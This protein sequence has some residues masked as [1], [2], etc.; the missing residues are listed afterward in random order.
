MKKYFLF[1]ISFLPLV[2]FSL[3]F[4]DST[5]AIEV[6][7]NIDSHCDSHKGE[8]V[9]PNGK[10]A[11]NFTDHIYSSWLPCSGPEFPDRIG[12]SIQKF[13][14]Y[15]YGRA[16]YDDIYSVS[17]YKNQEKVESGGPLDKLT[18]TAGTYHVWVGGGKST[19]VTIKYDL[20]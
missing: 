2:F 13:K 14:G 19:W 7:A 16:Q 1:F 12:Y 10:I 9:V 5:K 15:E 11:F 8:I 18:L 20:K 4:A 6:E 17:F 3:T